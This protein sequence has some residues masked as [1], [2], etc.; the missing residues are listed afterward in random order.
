MTPNRKFSFGWVVV[1]GGF[2]C[3]ICF[4]ISRHL[5]PY[6]VPEME[7]ALNLLHGSMGN[8]A[9]FYFF[10]YAIMTFVWGML[11][12]RIG[13]RK[14]ILMGMILLAI[15]LA[16]M[17][18]ISSVLTGSLFYTLCGIGGAALFVPLSPLISRWFGEKQRGTALGIAMSGLGAITLILGFVVPIILTNAS[19]QW[20][21]WLAA[22]LVLVLAFVSWFLLVERPEDKGL[23]YL[24]AAKE[25]SVSNGKADNPDQTESRLPLRWLLKGSTTWNLAGLYLT[26]G[27]AYA[28]FITFAVTYLEEIGWSFDVAA[29]VFATWGALAM[30]GQPAWGVISDHLAKKY[31]FALAL[32]LEA[33]GLLVFF[34]GN[35]MGIYIASGLI[36]F[37]DVG[38]PTI[39]AASMADYYEPRNIGT[40][41][42]F[43]T[44]NFSIGAIIG[45][46]LGGMLADK[47]ETLGTAILLSLGAIIVSLILSL[48]LRKPQ[49]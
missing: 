21:W 35:P 34:N 45:P 1:A 3:S 46:T 14:C 12:D 22:A 9:S 38:I 48:I 24:G 30:I 25:L 16:G 31:T 40:A 5:Y 29:R 19:W 7:A 43:I 11:T 39:M 20:S 17:G 41:F 2:L 33:I 47:T 13:A 44:L 23:S 27:I 32:G 49:R 18:F 26:R 42:G 28:I 10:A 36:G 6:V 4:G 15:G 37:G 8:I